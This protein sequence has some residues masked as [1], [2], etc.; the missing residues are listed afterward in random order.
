MSKWYAVTRNGV[1]VKIK[2]LE[3]DT[4]EKTYSFKTNPEEIAKITNP[5]T[6]LVKFQLV[7]VFGKVKSEVSI[8]TEEVPSLSYRGH[9][10]QV[11]GEIIPF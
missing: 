6:D 3:F 5:E 8:D 9:V 10:L 2:D 1:R 7:S 4:V 11:K